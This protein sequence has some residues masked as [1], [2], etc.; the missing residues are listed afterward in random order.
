MDYDDLRVRDRHFVGAVDAW[1]AGEVK[2]G[3]VLAP[4]AALTEVTLDGIGV[5]NRIAVAVR[6][7]YS[8]TDGTPSKDILVD[9]VRTGAQVV[10][11]D[12]VAVSEHGRIT[13]YDHGMYS[14]SHVRSWEREIDRG[15]QIGGALFALTLGH[16]GPRAASRPRTEATDRPA[17]PDDAWT[18][19]AASA[20]RYGRGGY[21]AAEIDEGRME[22]VLADFVAA[23]RRGRSAGF[24]MIELHM[25]Y[26]YL[27]GTFISPLTNRRSDEYGGSLENRLRYPLRVFDA[28]R[29]IWAD[30]PIGVA[31]T[32]S[33]W[34]SGGL[35]LSDAVAAARALKERGCTIVRVVAGQTVARY[36][37]H[38]DP[39][40]L[41]YLSDRIRNDARIATIAT[42]D[43][44]TVDHANTII[45]GG[46]ADLCLLR[47]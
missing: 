5:E 27:L 21:V 17:G 41:T 37:P 30:G 32:A 45:A 6:P 4:P 29:E 23:A 18:P 31:L 36:R 24:E 34:A 33:D 12:M 8:S 11:T 38:Y 42:G 19:L 47:I 9:R 2:P 14:D 26:G 15:D 10:F 28:V 25:A 3:I 43:I 22:D 13:P 46:R 39:Y 7:T 35:R 1:F 44:S 20:Q 40:F 16:A